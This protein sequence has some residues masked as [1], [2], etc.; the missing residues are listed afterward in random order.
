MG[1]VPGVVLSSSV[2][3]FP[4]AHT[5]MTSCSSSMCWMRLW[6]ASSFALLPYPPT[7]MLMTRR[8]ST[9]FDSISPSM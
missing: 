3:L 8:L 6:N 4:A 2:P 1:S 7:L 5:V 9:W